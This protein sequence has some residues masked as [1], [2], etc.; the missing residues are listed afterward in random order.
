MRRTS[1]YLPALR[2]HS[3]PDLQQVE[4]PCYSDLKD[5]EES[6][7]HHAKHWATPW[8]QRKQYVSFG[9]KTLTMRL[10]HTGV[11]SCGI[12]DHVPL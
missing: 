1:L 2:A 8:M 3:K 12:G 10:L 9:S 4:G 5:V 11:C 7:A 6:A